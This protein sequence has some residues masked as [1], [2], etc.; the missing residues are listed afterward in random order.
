MLE[1]QASMFINSVA[2]SMKILYTVSACRND[3]NYII[4][5]SD[6]GRLDENSP[7]YSNKLGSVCIGAA[8]F[9]FPDPHSMSGLIK[10]QNNDTASMAFS[11]KG[12]CVKLHNPDV[13]LHDSITQHATTLTDRMKA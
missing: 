1:W 11:E 13:P 2:I 7:L 5:E 3:L 9:K 6:E 4:E 8:S 12:T 10:I